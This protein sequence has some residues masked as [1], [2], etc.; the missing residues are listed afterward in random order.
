MFHVVVFPQRFFVLLSVVIPLCLAGNTRYYPLRNPDEAAVIEWGNS[1]IISALDAVVAEFGPQ[2]N[3][4]ALMEVETSPI[5]AVPLD[6]T[7]LTNKDDIAGNVVVMTDTDTDT[8]PVQLATAAQAAGAAALIVVHVDD[9]RPDEAPR[10][11]AANGEEE[12]AASIDIPVVA[13]SMTSASV[14]AMATLSENERLKI[15][16]LQE[17]NGLPERF[18]L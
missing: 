11:R 10:F 17:A 4:A 2:T 1:A 6:G 14:L 15:R 3:Q 12:A 16:S 5:F 8:T 9:S 13:I 7:T 18:V